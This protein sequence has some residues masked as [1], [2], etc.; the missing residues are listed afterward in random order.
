MHPVLPGFLLA[1]A[2]AVAAPATATSQI[3]DAIVVD[4]ETHELLNAPLKQWMRD[5]AAAARIRSLL[6][7]SGCTAAW[8]GYR[9][10]WEIRDSALY[11]VALHDKPCSRDSVPVPLDQLFPP[12][13]GRSAAQ[14]DGAVPA[15]WVTERLVVGQG[16]WTRPPEYGWEGKYERYL[17]L[18]I[19][20]GRVVGERRATE[21]EHIR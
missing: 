5:P 19:Q 14:A 11:L 6:R 3:P 9:A 8:R 17:M 2:V 16:K 12:A 1:I 20:A 7:P 4:G 15:D 10:T 13:V 21:P 18:D